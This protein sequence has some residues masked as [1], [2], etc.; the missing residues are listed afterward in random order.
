MPLLSKP[1][2]GPRTAIV[3]ITTGALTCVW[4][5]VW[6]FSFARD[7]SGQ[8]SRNT[9]FW[10]WGLFLTGITLLVIGFFLGHIGRS[11]RRAELPPP[12]AEHQEAQIQET[13]AAVPHPTV[14]GAVPGVGVPAAAP[15]AGV[16]PGMIAAGGVPGANA[17][18]AQP[19]TQFVPGATRR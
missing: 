4:T 5:G 3:Y 18:P 10:L 15:M 8:I 17:Q 1:A 12:E 13:A 19:S 2:F 9:E 11:A 14:P 16:M 6:Y 7:A